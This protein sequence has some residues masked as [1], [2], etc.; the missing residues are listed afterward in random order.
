MEERKAAVSSHWAGL[1]GE[2]EKGDTSLVPLWLGTAG[3]LGHSHSW[4]WYLK[5]PNLSSRQAWAL[6]E[7]RKQTAILCRERSRSTTLI[8]LSLNSS[9]LNLLDSLSSRLSQ[10]LGCGGGGYLGD[11]VSMVSGTIPTYSQGDAEAF[12][13]RTHG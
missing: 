5:L 11:A 9:A 3:S 10:L 8:T 2:T 12:L 13:T 4:H 7:L 1:W 6:L